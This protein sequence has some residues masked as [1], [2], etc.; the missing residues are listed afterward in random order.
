MR[1]DLFLKKAGVIKRRKVAHDLCQAGRVLIN[2]RPSKPSKTIRS[3]DIITIE[4]T[5]LVEKIKV[6]DP[7]E[8]RYQRIEV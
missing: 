6:I 7:E 5:D 1:I 3:G 4:G 8:G 2:G